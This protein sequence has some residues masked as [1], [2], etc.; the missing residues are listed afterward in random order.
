MGKSKDLI[1]TVKL[2]EAT[3]DAIKS[4]LQE[5]YQPQVVEIAERYKFF[6]RAQREGETVAEYLADLKKIARNAKFGDYL[7]TALRDQLVCGL[8]DSRCQKELLCMTSLTLEMAVQHARAF[9]AVSREA[10]MFNAADLHEVKRDRPNVHAPCFRCGRVGH[11]AEACWHVRTICNKCHKRGHLAVMCPKKAAERENRNWQFGKRSNRWTGANQTSGGRRSSSHAVEQTQSGREQHPQGQEQWQPPPSDSSGAEDYEVLHTHKARRGKLLTSVLV[12]GKQV[13]MELDTGAEITT[14]PSHVFEELFRDS[15]LCPTD[16]RLS[17]YDGSPLKILGEM[18]V[19]VEYKGQ[20]M[21]DSV[22]VVDVESRYPLLGRDWMFKVRFDWNEIVYGQMEKGDEHAVH[23]MSLS[24]LQN[25][26]QGLFSEGL[27]EVR[28]MSAQVKLEPGAQ[29]RFFKSRPVPFAL[30]DQV[31][32]ELERQIRAGELIPVETSEWAAPLV[33]VRKPGGS[34]RIC[35]DYKVTVNQSVVDQA[36]RLPTAEEI[37]STLANG[38]SFSK[39]DL[40]NAYK[41]LPLVP[42]SQA[43]LT[44]NTPLGLL[45]PTRLPFGLKV[46]PNLWQ[47]TMDEV[48]KGL[49][50]VACY[51][52][53]ILVTGG[54]REEHKANLEAVMQRLQER[55]LRLRREKCELFREKIVYLGHEI[56]KDGL[57]PTGERVKGIVNMPAP[58]NVKELLTFLG[59]MTYNAR[60]IPNLSTLLRPLYDLTRTGVKWAWAQEC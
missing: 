49:T 51:L 44:M 8:H 45:M 33:I 7:D 10:T 17:Q 59:L 16:K 32:K 27:G 58:G 34:V 39:L 60:F 47:R 22:L 35:A 54:S 25:K 1:N 13:T 48:L 30:R 3:F 38:E 55:G 14:L 26:Y 2:E 56:S 12:N 46:S 41:Q 50:G 24:T 31:N 6:Q 4:K 37:F 11:D 36:Y 28:G 57:R 53:D 15:Q 29:P 9:E 43:V 5:H 19:T 40:A 52:D 20:R 42:E 23:D 21:E 18:P